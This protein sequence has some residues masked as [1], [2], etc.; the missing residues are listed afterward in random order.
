MIE[1]FTRLSQVYATSR[2]FVLAFIKFG[3]LGKIVYNQGKGFD[4]NLLMDFAQFCDIKRIGTSPHHL[5]INVKEEWMNQ[6][7]INMLKR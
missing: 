6:T 1:L 4:N 3:L 5:Q 2:K 7:M